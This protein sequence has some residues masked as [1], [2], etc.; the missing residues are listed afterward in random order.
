MHEPALFRPLGTLLGRMSN[1]ATPYTV[2]MYKKKRRPSHGLC[3]HTIPQLIVKNRQ[4]DEGYKRF[5]DT[6]RRI[7]VLRRRWCIVLSP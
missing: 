1:L 5:K 6:S 7:Q 3:V 2:A 4:N